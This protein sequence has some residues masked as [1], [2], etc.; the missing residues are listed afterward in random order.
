MQAAISSAARDEEIATQ[1]KLSKK[2]MQ[3]NNFNRIVKTPIKYALSFFFFMCKLLQF[4]K[5]NDAIIRML[6]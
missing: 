6:K 3:L 4:I 1:V 5:Y 2:S